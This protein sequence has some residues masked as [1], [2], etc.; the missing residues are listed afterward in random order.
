MRPA[1]LPV[2]PSR[3]HAIQKLH[4][5]CPSVPTTKTAALNGEAESHIVAAHKLRLDSPIC[6]PGEIIIKARIRTHPW[7]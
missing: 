1:T 6:A 2:L 5:V 3:G 7:S 4:L